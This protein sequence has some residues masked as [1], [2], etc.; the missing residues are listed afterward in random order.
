M[1]PEPVSDE[2]LIIA[3]VV[4]MTIC[5]YNYAICLRARALRA[6]AR[7]WTVLRGGQ[8]PMN[9]LK[10]R[11]CNGSPPLGQGFRPGVIKD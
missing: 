4:K 6:G 11:G 8:I 1:G 5:Q 9:P 2:T 7:A 10:P 3:R